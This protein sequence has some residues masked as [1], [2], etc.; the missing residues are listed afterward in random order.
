MGRVYSGRAAEIALDGP[1]TRYALIS[2]GS[3]EIAVYLS[4]KGS[5]VSACRNAIQRALHQKHSLVA[6]ARRRVGPVTGALRRS[7]RRARPRRGAGGAH[8]RDAAAHRLAIRSRLSR[9]GTGRTEVS[10]LGARAPVPSRTAPL[11]DERRERAR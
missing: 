1:N 7:F 2:M 9:L 6:A 8:E 5:P 11:A 4:S 10:S 3:N